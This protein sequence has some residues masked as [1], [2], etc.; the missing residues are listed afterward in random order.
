MHSKQYSAY[1]SAIGL[2]IEA[3]NCR[4]AQIFRDTN[5]G[6]NLKL[7]VFLLGGAVEDIYRYL[8]IRGTASPMPV[9]AGISI[10]LWPRLSKIMIKTVICATNI[11][12]HSQ[13][14]VPR[15]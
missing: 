9:L 12:I 6:R 1:S 13:T 8:H 14:K 4:R 7:T 10:F 15:L 2:Q 5:S 3:S 11:C